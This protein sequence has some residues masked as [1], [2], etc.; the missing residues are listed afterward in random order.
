MNK[1]GLIYALLC[2]LLWSF[3]PVVARFGQVTLDNIQFLF[4]SNAL[5]LLVVGCCWMFKKPSDDVNTLS[6]RQAGFLLLL[7][8]LGCALYYLCLYYGYEHGNGLEVLI[9]QYTWPMMIV[10]LSVMLLSETLGPRQL[11]AVVL[12]FLGIVLVLTRG[13]FS[14]LAF[15]QLSVNLIV[16]AGAFCFALFSVLSKKTTVDAL[17]AVVLFFIGGTMVSTLALVG[18]SE[19]AWPTKREW[20]SVLV[21]GAFINGVSYIFWLQAL[22]QLKAQVAATLVFIT[23]ILSALWMV[24]LFGETFYLIYVIGFILVLVSGVLTIRAR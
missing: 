19:F 13:E 14:E 4:W 24:V 3:I 1:A 2:V 11:L 16:L 22:K 23:P 9:M 18:L 20:F 12:G 17:T 7:G 21:N 15:T 5:S 8:A 6:A 10:L